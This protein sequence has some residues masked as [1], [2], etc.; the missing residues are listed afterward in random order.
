MT[1]I[2][3]RAMEKHHEEN[4]LPLVATKSYLMSGVQCDLVVQVF[5]DRIFVGISQLKGKMGSFLTCTVEES[6]ID[7]SSTYHV[8]SLLGK[9]DDA[10][11]EIYA[12]QITERIA[13]VERNRPA[14]C[15][16][17]GSSP[18]PPVLLGV[19]IDKS[20]GRV[21]GI[22]NAIVDQAV[23]MYIDLTSLKSA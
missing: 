12:R 21:K 15:G 1:V 3:A 5:S 7:G 11:L 17:D 9:R 14:Y 13:M 2:E 4:S 8:S 20:K 23:D 16:S 6:I 10:L 19:S 18:I 22:F